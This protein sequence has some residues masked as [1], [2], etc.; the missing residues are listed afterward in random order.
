MTRQ[1]PM[2]QPLS[3]EDR[4]YLLMRGEDARVKYLDEQYPDAEDEPDD[5]EG[6]EAPA[7]PD[8]YARW[9]KAELE[10]EVKG[11]NDQGA[12]IEVVPTGAGGKVKVEDLVK[13]LQ[14]DD[15]KSE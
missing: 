1:I 10:A 13:A 3:E 14:E 6:E 2:D 4:A 5:A 12:G 11:R 9:P 15:A 7:L 8:D